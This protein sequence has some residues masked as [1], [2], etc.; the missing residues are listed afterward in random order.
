MKTF[1]ALMVMF[2]IYITKSY[3][4]VGAI[5]F[6]SASYFVYWWM[7][8]RARVNQLKYW[9]K[10][11]EDVFI[12]KGE[13]FLMPFKEQDIV[14][15]TESDPF[16]ERR[17]IEKLLRDAGNNFFPDH[18][19]VVVLLRNHAERINET[20]E[21]FIQY[22][23]EEIMKARSERHKAMSERNKDAYIKMHH[24]FNPE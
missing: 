5:L 21:E 11:Y 4:I 1:A 13:P 24:K 2:F 19:S 14:V 15:F 16:D 10:R 6:L 8:E 20:H 12:I 23:V 7:K 22:V 3:G 9:G 17:R 18:L